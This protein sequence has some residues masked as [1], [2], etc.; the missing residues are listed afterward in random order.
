MVNYTFKTENSKRYRF[1]NQLNYS[2]TF[3][4]LHQKGRYSLVPQL[5]IAGEVYDSN[6][7]YSERIRKTSGDIFFGK[8]G[9]EIGK[10]K[11][12][13]G[14]NVMLPIQQN[15]ADRRVEANYRWSLNLN[16]SL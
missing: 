10:D 15:L 6:Y 3:F 1:G 9:I 11:F 4:Y 7:Q 5:G 8:A 2:G 12:S 14:A 13:L 16:Y